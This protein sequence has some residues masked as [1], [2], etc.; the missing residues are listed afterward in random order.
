MLVRMRTFLM[1]AILAV[2]A[3]A[4][5]GERDVLGLALL[6]EGRTAEAIGE[7]RAAKREAEIAGEEGDGLA[8]ILDHLGQAE[9]HAG[10]YRAAKKYF[11]KAVHLPVREAALKSEALSNAGQ[12]CIALGEKHQAE[13]YFRQAMALM[14]D[15]PRLW[16]LLGQAMFLQGKHAEAE[17]A[18]RQALRNGGEDA[19]VLNDLAGLLES[20]NRRDA[21]IT[22]M[23][24]A[25]A[26]STAGQSRARILRNLAVLEW[27][28]GERQ[29]AL[30]LLRQAL[31]E[32]ESAVG[33]EHPDMAQ[34]LDDYAAAL[35]KTGDKSGSRRAA[36][37]AEAIRS[38]FAG[39]DGRA[40]V[41]W[42][43]LRE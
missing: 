12:A 10:R 5:W 6:K 33:V 35:E 8:A 13:E 9:F 26:R 16:H 21:A 14:P 40:T 25:V 27:K 3:A 30:D 31:S 4:D 29:R 19:N 38:A 32:T 1:I 34:V 18:F 41:G 23:R 22:L 11:N 20:R 39:Y 17:M 42:R 43:E 2:P 36:G 24:Q 15:S 28:A 7:L 37:R